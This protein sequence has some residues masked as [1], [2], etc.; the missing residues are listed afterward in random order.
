MKK[1]V[2]LLAPLVLM[3]CNATQEFASQFDYNKV[4]GGNLDVYQ[5]D[6]ADSDLSPSD[7]IRFMKLNE[8]SNPIN[9][10]HQKV[11]VYSYS[12]LG[13]GSVTINGASVSSEYLGR[14]TSNEV[15]KNALTRVLSV[16]GLYQQG[17]SWGADNTLSFELIDYN[18]GTKIGIYPPLGGIPS[19]LKNNPIQGSITG[20]FKLKNTESGKLVIDEVLTVPF[21]I[22]QDDIHFTKGKSTTDLITGD[23]VLKWE[24]QNNK[25]KTPQDKAL[26]KLINSFS[27]KITSES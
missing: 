10:Y 27:E 14:L 5:Y 18:P 2:F 13:A 21:T 15:V 1:S 4:Y 26:Y 3:G 11:F 8:S 19:Q 20:N 12:A 23:T 24:F 25:F 9:Q 6:F 7:K 22:E 17:T 16:N